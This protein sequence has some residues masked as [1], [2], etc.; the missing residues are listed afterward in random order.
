MIGAVRYCADPL[1]QT[2][3]TWAVVD[4]RWR[5][6]LGSRPVGTLEATG[7]G[8]RRVA[9]AARSELMANRRLIERL[10][11]CNI[12]LSGLHTGFASRIFDR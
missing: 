4:S 11:Y 5:R 1:S 3:G 10:E 7:Q 8:I 12:A 9:I 2:F 6:R